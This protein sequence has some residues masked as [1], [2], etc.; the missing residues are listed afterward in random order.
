VNLVRAATIRF[1]GLMGKLDDIVVHIRGS[2]LRTKEFIDKAQRMIPLD[3][4]TRWNSWYYMI[5]V[6]LELEMHIDFYVRN[7]E[8][9]VEDALNRA[10]WVCFVRYEYFSSTSKILFLRMKETLRLLDILYPQCC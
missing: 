6:A 3:N 7:Q 1:I 10:D 4:R 2:G 5:I 8:D 9:L